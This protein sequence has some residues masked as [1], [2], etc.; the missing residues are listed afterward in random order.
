MT[1]DMDVIKELEELGG[2]PIPQIDYFHRNCLGY[3]MEG[4]NIIKLG[5]ESFNLK[6]LPESIGNLKRLQELNL[7]FNKFISLP[8]AVGEL[9]NLKGLYI[10]SNNLT[11]IPELIGKLTQLQKLDLSRNNFTTFPEFIGNLLSL[12]SL[13]ITRNKIT[14]L[15]ESIGKLTQLQTLRLESNKLSFLP[16]S[17]GDL[18]LLQNLVL[19]D[20]Q[21][22]NLPISIGDLDSL[23]KLDLRDNLLITL[24]ESFGKLSSLQE[25][26]LGRNNLTSLPESFGELKVLQD[27][28]LRNN[29]LT[30]LP[31]SFGN[32]KNLKIIY[33]MK[34]PMTSL[35]KSFGSLE[36]LENLYLDDAKLT[37]LPESIGELKKINL[38]VIPGNLLTLIPKPLIQLPTLTQFNIKNN[39]IE[40]N[41]VNKEVYLKLKENNVRV[42]TNTF[43]KIHF[44]DVPEP[45]IT[46]LDEISNQTDTLIRFKQG[47]NFTRDGIEIRLENNRV[48]E[49]CLN[50]K[51][52][53]LPE[54]FGELKKLQILELSYNNLTSLPESFGNLKDLHT[55]LLNN[56][57]LTFLPET[58]VNLTSLNKLNLSNNQFSEIPTVLWPLKEL[59][60][61]FLN[62]NPLSVEEN[63]LIQKI[64]DLILNYL[65]EKATI[66]IFISHAVTDFEP[67]HIGELVEYLKKQKE[68]SEVY[69]CEENL[70]GNIDEWMLDTVQKCQLLL[71]FATNKSIFNSVDCANELKLAEKFSIPVIPIKG[72]D[73]GWADLA[74]IKLSRELG[75]EFDKQNFHGF[76]NDLYRYIHNF[77]REIDLMSREER[78]KGITDIY[79][80][81][82]LILDEA[83]SEL[84]RKVNN[85]FKKNAKLEKTISSILK[86]ME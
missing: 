28:N 53:T 73:V 74:E 49:L 65:R 84:N 45:E 24:P 86:K 69:F 41:E 12:K 6:E 8:E 68:I 62:N 16:H 22:E 29:N 18:T 57:K 38:I 44:L 17:I 3:E 21:F 81:F 71:F 66:Q 64:P 48:V 4:E 78:E 9:E 32:L 61:L 34:N 15:P 5:L 7:G 1:N 54:S 72:D 37:T 33:L 42:D 51:L 55:L 80:R 30:T 52:Q 31:E 40:R 75:L 67:Y 56:N 50:L 10:E 19:K 35:P 25:L 46:V 47:K 43:Q 82:R 13:D 20:N 2:K 70:A 85:L 58:F 11:I 76:C 60:E 39:P 14:S 23:Q 63:N 26:N 59:H 77:K 79:E 36:S 27:L 83:I